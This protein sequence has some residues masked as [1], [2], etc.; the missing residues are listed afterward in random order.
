MPKISNEAQWA[1]VPDGIYFSP[2]NNPRSICFYDFT[3]R[4]TRQIFRTD[5]DLAEGMSISPDRR[6]LLYSQIDESN[7]DIMLVSNFR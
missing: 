5:K 7:S 3:T 6:Y 4:H 1:V 2:Q